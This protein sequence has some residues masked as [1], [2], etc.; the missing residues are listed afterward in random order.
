MQPDDHFYAAVT[1]AEVLTYFYLWPLFFI[2][3]INIIIR[4]REVDNFLHH[5]VAL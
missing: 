5:N 4:V 3:A 2:I 1:S